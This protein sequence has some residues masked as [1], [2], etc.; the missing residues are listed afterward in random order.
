VTRVGGALPGLYGDSANHVQ[1]RCLVC[2]KHTIG[3]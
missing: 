1:D 2:T 3:S